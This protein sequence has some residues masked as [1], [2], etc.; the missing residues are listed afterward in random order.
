MEYFVK[1]INGNGGG[2]R[3]LPGSFNMSLSISEI[4]IYSRDAEHYREESKAAIN[5][6]ALLV[7][8]GRSR[9]GTGCIR[10]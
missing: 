5:R 9:E 4:G 2:G 8:Q 3:T 6:G 7:C 10:H 1:F